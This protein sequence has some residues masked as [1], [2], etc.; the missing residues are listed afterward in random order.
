M[1]GIKSCWPQPRLI[2][3]Q[4]WAMA[5]LSS[6]IYDSS[7]CLFTIYFIFTNEFIGKVSI[8]FSYLRFFC[9]RYYHRTTAKIPKCNYWHPRCR[10]INSNCTS[11]FQEL[12]LFFWLLNDSYTLWWDD[13]VHQLVYVLQY[14][15]FLI[16]IFLW[17]LLPVRAYARGV[18]HN[19]L[20]LTCN[21]VS[22]CNANSY[23]SIFYC[24]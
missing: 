1:C 4:P 23:N 12:Q 9:F 7:A 3:V 6:F 8:C 14:I 2:L 5:V 22:K 18:L 16:T 15:L 21:L 10:H 24:I 11:Y 20:D 17:L 13:T 19:Q